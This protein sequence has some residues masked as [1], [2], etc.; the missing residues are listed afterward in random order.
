MTT[1][2]A[3]AGT[4][5]E[6]TH[7]PAADAARLAGISLARLQRYERAGL[8][9]PAQRR[10]RVRLYSAAQVVQLR[11]IRRLQDDLGVNLAGIEVILRLREQIATLQALTAPAGLP[12]SIAS[13]DPHR[14]TE[15]R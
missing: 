13:S 12:M 7:H 9:R 1:G 15:E 11:R 2:K 5:A 14:G 10:G 3:G 6:T 8:L 4:A